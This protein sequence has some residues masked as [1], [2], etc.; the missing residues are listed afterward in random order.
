MIQRINTVSFGNSPVGEIKNGVRKAQATRDEILEGA[1][2]TGGAV[3]VANGHKVLRAVSGVTQK[4]TT[5][6]GQVSKNT[7]K[8]EQYFLEIFKSAKAIKGFG[9]IAKAAEMPAVRGFGKVFGGFAA[10]SFCVKD[11]S[12]MFN[13]FGGNNFPTLSNFGKK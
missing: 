5:S 3:A 1:I 12:I 10:V 8:F 6:I 7:S 2:G 13:T 9:W 4:T 11:L